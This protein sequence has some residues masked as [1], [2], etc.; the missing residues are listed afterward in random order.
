[1]EL[2]V[3]TNF[4]LSLDDIKTLNLLYLPLIGDDAITLY[5]FLHNILDKKSLADNFLSQDEILDLL[6]YKLIKFN[7]ALEKLEGIGLVRTFV[8]DDSTLILLLTP[9]TAKNFLKDTPLGHLLEAK[10]GEVSFKK[11]VKSFEI[12]PLNLKEYKETTK[13]FGEVFKDLE[14]QSNKVEENI[15]GRRPNHRSLVSSS[16]FDYDLFLSKIDTNLISSD[17]EP[18]FKKEMESTSFV[19]NFS[20]EQMVNLFNDS[21]DKD[22]HFSSNL[23]KKKAQ[24]LSNFLNKKQVAKPFEDE[25]DE[26]AALEKLDAKTLLASLVGKDYP[27]ILLQKVNELYINLNM[28]RGVINLMIILVYSQK[29]TIPALSYFEKMAKS[30]Q[31]EGVYTTE[32]AVNKFISD[33]ASAKLPKKKAKKDFELEDWQIK[34]MEEIMKGFDNIG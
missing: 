10:I 34:G 15:Y 8:S 5:T 16:D 14:F 9:Y 27:N 32:D 28:P 23:F 29:E 6:G 1:M 21:I 11:I 30:W 7:K 25:K 12:P 13:S 4:N 31:N 17:K 33:N 24:S 3:Y 2:K 20:L 22:G 26:V 19:Y 18:N